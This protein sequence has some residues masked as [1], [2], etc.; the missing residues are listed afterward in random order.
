MSARLPL[1]HKT[2]FVL[3]ERPLYE[4]TCPHAVLLSVSRVYRALGLPALV[5]TILSLRKRRRGFAE[6]QCIE[7]ISLLQT[8]GAGNVLKIC[9]CWP[10]TLAWNGVWAIVRPKRRWCG[11][12][13]N[14]STT[15]SWRHC[16]PGEQCRRVSFSLRASRYEEGRGYQPMVA[17]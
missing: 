9:T 2:P 4:A 16:G 8:V 3:D 6:A 5:G 15:R 17:V 11:G 10:G 13:W 12:F 14:A 1:L 7:C